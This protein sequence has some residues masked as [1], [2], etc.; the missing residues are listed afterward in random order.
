MRLF[1]YL[2]LLLSCGKLSAQDHLTRKV[3]FIGNSYIYV[4]NLPQL[5][6]DVALAN[7]DTLIFDS[8][9]IGG[10]T[11]NAHANN[12]VTQTKIQSQAWDYV[13]LQ[14]Q[15][16]EPSF[17][18]E[19]VDAQTTP[20]ALQLDA[21]VDASD[22]CALTVFFQTW[23]RKFGDAANCN[24]YPPVCTY[25]GMQDRLL[26]SYTQFAD[27]CD[28]I[29]A[30]VGE[31]WR[32]SIAQ[33]S[34]LNLY[35]A[36]NSHP[37]LAGSYLAACVFYETV[38]R[39][40]VVGTT[41]TAG[42]DAA[43]AAHLQNMAHNTVSPDPAQWN[44]GTTDRCLVANVA[45]QTDD[46]TLLLFPNPA[47]DELNIGLS[48]PLTPGSTFRIVNA[49]GQTCATGSLGS[50]RVD[51]SNLAAGVYTLLVQTGNGSYVASFV[52]E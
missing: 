34:D 30:P 16:Q 20:F 7:G 52:K 5:L 37:S 31:A 24:V 1:I 12:A 17:S 41:Y 4:N 22:S 9:A 39:K 3:L 47:A 40:S 10:A 6:Y 36:D 15:S 2:V 46:R 29:M 18:P 45:E 21:L 14:A 43:V 35:S 49:H 28:A 38:F 32:M 33:N 44:I 11:F 26:A 42:L 48:A 19:Q 8:N 25:E 51:V 27:Q 50:G 13:V 23:G